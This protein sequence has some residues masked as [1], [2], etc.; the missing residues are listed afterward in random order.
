MIT[1]TIASNMINS[2]I[3]D[4]GGNNKASLGVF[5]SQVSDCR[6]RILVVALGASILRRWTS[7]AP[8][9]SPGIYCYA[10]PAAIGAPC[11]G[12]HGDEDD[13]S[14]EGGDCGDDGDNNDDGGGDGSD[15]W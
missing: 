2:D 3:N 6:L 4:S 8:D 10:C 5:C 15:G 12:G 1:E 13:G 7:G 11:V 9:P 14:D